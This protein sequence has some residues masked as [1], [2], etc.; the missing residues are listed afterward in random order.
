[1]AEVS[2]HQFINWFRGR[3]GKLVYRRAH[4]GKVSVYRAPDM[5]RVKW[6]PAQKDHRLR[7][8]L[9]QRQRPAVEE[10]HGRSAETGELGHGRLLLVF[11]PQSKATREET[12]AAPVAS[13]R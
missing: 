4:N 1:M 3:I 9:S 6:S 11:Q 8:L 7:R 2:F 5:S 12:Q 13:P 10:A